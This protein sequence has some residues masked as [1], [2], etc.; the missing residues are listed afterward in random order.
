M[1]GPVGVTQCPIP[2]GKTFL[3]DFV[4]EQSGT[5]WYHSHSGSQY[6]DGLRAMVIVHD[7]EVESKYKYDD[8][9]LFSVSDWYHDTSDV[10][11][12]RQLTR[13]N[14]TG[15]EPIPQSMLFNDSKNVTVS[16]EPE[17][18]YIIR[19]AN[20]GIM[21]SQYIFIEDH[22]F[23][24]V[25]VDGVYTKPARA[26]MLYLAVG[27]RA[28]ILLKTKSLSDVNK[29]FCI[30]QSL[31][32]SM[33]DAIPKD[34]QVTSISY[35]SYDKS[36]A[37]SVPR[38]EFYDIDSYE[39]FDDFNLEP[40]INQPLLPEPDHVIHLNLHMDNLGDG[41]N[42][43]FF[44]NLTY[45][46]PKVPTL[47]T[48]LTAPDNLVMNDRIYGENTNAFVLS[49]GDVVDLVVDN[50]DSNKHPLHMHGH[51][52]QV[53]VRS[54]EYE[55]PHHF[56]YENA[57]EFPEHPCVRD[58]LTVNT[59]GH[60]V[61]RFRA[62]NPGIWFFHCHLDFHLEQGLAIV[63][64]EAPDVLRDQLKYDSLPFDYIQ[65]CLAADM[66]TKGN[67]AGNTEDWLD[68]A[69]QNLQPKALP[70][71]FTLKGYIALAA[72]AISALWGLWEISIFGMSDVNKQFQDRID[73]EKLVVKD[74]ILK[75]SDEKDRVS[76]KNLRQITEM[77]AELD[78]LDHKFAQL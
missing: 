26:N 3:Y 41:V 55:V 69:G 25:E 53:V 24:I 72:C 67:A 45:V 78:E 61:I 34:L 38:K 33:L 44:N 39:P 77:L 46:T 40:L 68:L 36:M 7:S 35:L 31:D 6:S 74:L 37:K 43:A 42:Y 29:Q 2:P 71:G 52:Y 30:V 4:V 19:I 18:T 59:Y 73:H 20:I 56:Q 76:G 27:Q 12:E 5:Y 17:T 16:V 54:Q 64:V 32:T 13:Y 10:L 65:T 70:L 21:V 58:T 23:E 8:E 14:P 63:L 47:L 48:A 11:A 15:A 75:L 22:E 28:S 49:G 57:S 9:R 51:Q 1:D 66:P 62:D 50:D 60:A